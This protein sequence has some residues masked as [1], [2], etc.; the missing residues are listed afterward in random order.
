M[1]LP[2]RAAD[3]TLGAIAVA[4]YRDSRR[5]DPMDLA[6]AEAFAGQTALAAVLSEARTERERLTVFEER[7]RIARDL[8][9]LVIQRLFATGM[10]L[11][12][13]AM[14]LTDDDVRERVE[15]SVADLDAT[16]RDV[17]ATI[18]ELQM[19]AAGS[20]RAEVR[21]L[22]REYREVLGFAPE[23]RIKGPIDTAVTE[24]MR[25]PLLKVLREALSNIA[26]HARATRVQ[27]LLD[28]A[29][30][31][32][33]LTVD[34]DGVGIPTNVTRSGLENV[35]AR[36]A[37]LGGGLDLAMSPLSGAR[38]RWSIPLSR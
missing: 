24:A 34:D 4:N 9:D 19:P 31:A 18:F 12:A 32:V 36:A 27:I 17:R 13:A 14:R 37:A 1:L 23:L 35:R 26:R 7:D 22:V 38:V 11:Q 15:R 28:V 6:M 25:E 29:D 3:L 33:T 21:G 10:Q 8:H 5:F 16:I 20:A 30:G 2:M